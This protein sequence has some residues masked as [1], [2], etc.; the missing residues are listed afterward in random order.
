MDLETYIL[1]VL[2]EHLLTKDY[3]QLSD[4]EALNRME[5]LKVH[6]KNIIKEHQNSLPK[7]KQP[8]SREA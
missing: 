7:T 8:I 2:Q 3:I 1:Q 5:N 6:L 4:S